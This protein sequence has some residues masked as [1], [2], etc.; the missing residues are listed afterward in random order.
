MGSELLRL[1]CALATVVLPLAFA[2]FIVSRQ[3]ASEKRR[4]K[5]I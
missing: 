4:K 5:D 2:W 3:S 1:I